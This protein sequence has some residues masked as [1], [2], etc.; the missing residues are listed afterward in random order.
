MILYHFTAREYLPSIASNGLWK[1][2]VA[3]THRAEDCLNA[4]WLT[5]QNNAA[6]HGLTD[7]HVLTS[8]E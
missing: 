7:E 6:G 2:E 5:T 3:L 8:D 1:G 4:V